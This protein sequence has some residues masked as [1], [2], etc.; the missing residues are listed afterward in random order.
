MFPT[1]DTSIVMMYITVNMMF[2]T[3]DTIPA[4]SKH[5]HYYRVARKFVTKLVIIFM[6]YNCSKLRVVKF[7]I[8][9]FVRWCIRF[10]ARSFDRLFV[11]SFGR[12]LDILSENILLIDR[13]YF[14]ETLSSMPV[15]IVSSA[16]SVH[17]L[18]KT[19]SF[20]VGTFV[21]ASVRPSV[22]Q[23][24]HPSVRLCVCPEW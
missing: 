14:S 11:R 9:W 16:G 3:C 22:R 15:N 2:S 7:W 24:V 20:F 23:F 10:F 6:E 5:F 12:F 21:Y 18:A 1:N 13:A 8:R 4:K 19:K 17:K